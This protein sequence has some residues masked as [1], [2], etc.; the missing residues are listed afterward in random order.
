MVMMEPHVIQTWTVKVENYSCASA[1]ADDVRLSTACFCH[2]PPSLPP[3]PVARFRQRRRILQTKLSR[4]R[5]S[6]SPGR[7]IRSLWVNQVEMA[8][9]EKEGQPESLYFWHWTTTIAHYLLTRN[10]GQEKLVL[11]TSKDRL[12]I[13]TWFLRWTNRTPSATNKHEI[14]VNSTE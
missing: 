12:S 11:L 8:K 2:T 9:A 13:W 1:F 5:R 3:D 6:A 14:D 10:C 4:S 7:V